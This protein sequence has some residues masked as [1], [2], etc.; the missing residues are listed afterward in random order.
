[1]R[2][3]SLD[4]NTGFLSPSID[5]E[6]QPERIWPSAL[7]P[8]DLEV[9]E[10]IALDY[11]LATLQDIAD[12]LQRRTGACTTAGTVRR[13]L[14]AAGVNRSGPVAPRTTDGEAL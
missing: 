14:I 9:L 13:L 8:N 11:P 3:P 5:R 6:D 7:I 12:E 4:V 1:M 2:K 10:A